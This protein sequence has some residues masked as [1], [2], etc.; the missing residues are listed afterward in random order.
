MSSDLTQAWYVYCVLPAAA[1]A[2][3]ETGRLQGAPVA[4][5][6]V[7]AFTVLTSLVPRALFDESHPANK[8]DDPAWMAA[9]MQ[10]HHD[11]NAAATA[12]GPCLPLAFGALFSSLDLLRGWLAPR[13]GALRAALAQ[14]AAQT[15][16]ALALQEDVGRHAAWLDRHDPA[17]RRLSDAA[18]GAGAGTAF[19]LSRQR[20]K[21]RGTARAASIAAAAER[22]EEWLAR[23]SLG[24][25]A[26]AARAGLPHWTVLEPLDPERPDRLPRRLEPL[27]DE[28]AP[29]GLTLRLTGP[30]PAYRAARAATAPAPTPVPLSVRET[31]DG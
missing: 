21:A 4:A 7:G 17:M 6:P 22:V 26:E 25:V 16:W 28:L 18:V 31:V 29:T 10:A 27:A 9:C 11:V 3:P 1:A 5:V 19:L 8:T 14:V 13:E 30:W 24:V 12:S 2:P 23:A 15:E 20:D